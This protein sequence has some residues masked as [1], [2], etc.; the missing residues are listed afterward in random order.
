MK[1][2]TFKD[3]FDNSVASFAE[4]T[5]FSMIN[6]DS[7]TY[8]QFGDLVAQTRERLLNA[9]VTAGDKVAIFSRSTI[10][11]P[12]A[13]FTCVTSGIIVVPILPDFTGEE[14]AKLLKHS[15]TKALFV[16]EQLYKSIPQDAIES[17][18]ICIS[19]TNLNTIAEKKQNDGQVI[20][21]GEAVVPN[22]D[23]LAVIIY[24]SGTTSSP[25]GVMLT[26]KA[27]MSQLE[28]Y[29][30]FF[31]IDSSDVFLSILPLS[32][33]YE[34]SIGMLYPFSSGCHVVYL[35]RMPTAAALIPAFKKI[36]PTVFICVPLVLDKIYR[37]KI[38]ATITAT[39][40]G[41]AAYKL[42][43]VRKIYH[44]IAGRKLAEIFG[45]NIRFIGI[46]G[47]KLNSETDRF[48]NEGRLPIAIGYGLTETAPLLF[49]ATVGQTRVGTT[50][51]PCHGIEYRIVNEDENG[52]GELEVKT[53][54]IMLGY[55]KNPEAT[56]DAITEDGWFRTKD[57]CTVAKNGHLSITGRVNNMIVGPSGENI[58]PEEIEN[59]I[60][61][62][63]LVTESIVLMDK[64]HLLALVAYDKDKLDKAVKALR[65]EVGDA[66]QE[67]HNE[68][69]AY[70]NERVNKFSRISA[71]EYHPEGFEKTPS[72]K[73]KRFLYTKR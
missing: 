50:G 36:R 24:T 71:I 46:G 13:Y 54:S 21:R 63:E 68:V 5:A 31:T 66:I 37:A 69:R 60:N 16:S 10:Y 45:G 6:G 20:P 52:Q 8:R 43:P 7:V 12:V 22:A 11:W 14:V 48:L 47:A 32:H 64:G 51:T 4:K 17:L 3:L 2:E 41:A 61:T 19:T 73:I 30:H 67:I 42:A 53:P 34:C 28:M 15:E 72:Q 57:I 1:P 65:N 29:V 56:R 33:T 58:Y 59:V 55:Y 23:D 38:R 26:H 49:G 62:H 39:K 44:R 40:I 9:G 27:F 35:D 25:K 70:V 18:N